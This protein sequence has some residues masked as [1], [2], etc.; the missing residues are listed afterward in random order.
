MWAKACLCSNYV[1][2][3]ID[4]NNKGKHTETTTAAIATTTIHILLTK[5]VCVHVFVPC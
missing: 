2:I 5:C 1:R 4:E 3:A